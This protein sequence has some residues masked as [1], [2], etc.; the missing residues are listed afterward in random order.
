M[1]TPVRAGAQ[2]DGGNKMVRRAGLEPA[3]TS[4]KGF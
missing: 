1:K 4:L 3:T 2:V